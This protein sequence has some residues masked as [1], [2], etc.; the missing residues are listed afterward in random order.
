MKAAEKIGMQSTIH[1]LPE[2]TSQSSLLSL[3]NE[4]NVDPDVDGILVQLPVP[5]HM[6]E[7][8]ICNSVVPEKDVDGFHITNIGRF[9]LDLECFGPCTPLG[10]MELIRRY[11]ECIK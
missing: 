5:P 4:L 11:G 10:V 6:E 1:H 7:K 2:D 3:I 8:V 9:C